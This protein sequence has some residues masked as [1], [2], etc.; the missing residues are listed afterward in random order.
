MVFSSQRDE[1][2]ILHNFARFFAH[3]S[4]GFCTPCRAGTQVIART[5]EQVIQKTPAPNAA[6]DLQELAQL[7]RATS[8]CGLGQTAACALIDVMQQRP[9]RFIPLAGKASPSENSVFY[10]G[11][12]P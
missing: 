2:E 1:L 7:L 11:E 10:R 3:E 12:C 6:R 8:H 4:C 9:E 5:L